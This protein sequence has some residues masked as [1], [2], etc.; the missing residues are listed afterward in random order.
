MSDEVKELKGQMLILKSR[1]DALEGY[2]NG[3]T[4]IVKMRLEALEKRP[5]VVKKCNCETVRIVQNYC[6]H[7]ECIHCKKWYS[8]PVIPKNKKRV[9]L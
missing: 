2:I 1:V 7:H 4:E 9:P 6:E 8:V 3:M 5:V